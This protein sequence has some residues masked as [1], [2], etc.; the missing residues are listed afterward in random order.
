M[1]ALHHQELNHIGG[2]GAS[3]I[4]AQKSTAILLAACGIDAIWM[5][6]AVFLPS[7]CF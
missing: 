6:V 3:G 5:V 2:N 7:S 1:I 4:V